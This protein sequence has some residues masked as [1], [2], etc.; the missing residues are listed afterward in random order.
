VATG[1]AAAAAA[2]AAA[3]EC[4]TVACCHSLWQ[5]PVREKFWVSYVLMDLQRIGM[6]FWAH[7]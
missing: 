4:E 2:P 7:T 5:Q 6:H 1:S 3:T